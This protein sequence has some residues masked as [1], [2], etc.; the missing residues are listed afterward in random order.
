M[1]QKIEE[2]LPDGFLI[3]HQHGTGLRDGAAG[4]EPLLFHLGLHQTEDFP[5]DVANIERR[6]LELIV[7][8]LDFRHVQDVADE[9]EEMSAAGHEV[10]GISAVAPVADRKST[11]MNSSH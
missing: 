11:R 3:R 9:I 4:A 10:A 8:G 5:D 2:H 1:R 7:P 6:K